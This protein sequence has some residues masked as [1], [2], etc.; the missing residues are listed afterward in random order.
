MMEPPP[1]QSAACL[2]PTCASPALA[3]C[4][5]RVADS[6]RLTLREETAQVHPG[7]EVVDVPYFYD[8]NMF[9]ACERMGIA[10]RYRTVTVTHS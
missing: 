2:W 10:M 6:T 7:I 3:V 8:A 4:R 1:T 5:Q 9:N